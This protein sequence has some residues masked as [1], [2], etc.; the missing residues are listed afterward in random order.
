MPPISAAIDDALVGLIDRHRHSL[1][2]G[3]ATTAPASN[4]TPPTESC[5]FPYSRDWRTGGLCGDF[6]SVATFTTWAGGTI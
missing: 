4:S 3:E 2:F 1:A 6:G 5:R